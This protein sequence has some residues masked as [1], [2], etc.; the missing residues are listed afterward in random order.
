[1]FWKQYPN[2]AKVS[3]LVKEHPELFD[4]I[5]TEQNGADGEH[6]V[7]NLPTQSTEPHDEEIH[8]ISHVTEDESLSI[9]KKEKELIIR[10][11]RKN[12]NKRK[13]A[14][15]DLGIS[16]RTLYRKIKQYDLED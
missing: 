13:Y 11:L 8:D 10:A 4:G 16:E 12:N 3:Q 6:V 9:E 15:R 5:D 2:Q 1:M 14:A 7:L